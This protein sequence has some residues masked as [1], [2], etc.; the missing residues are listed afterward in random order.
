MIFPHRSPKIYLPRFVESGPKKAYSTRR[1]LQYIWPYL[2]P[3]DRY[4]RLLTFSSAIILIATKSL[5]AYAPFILKE[6]VNSLAAAN[7]LLFYS[8]G[9]FMTYALSRIFVIGLQELRVVL[10]S[11]VIVQAMGDSSRK[12]FSHLHSLDYTFHQQSTRVTMFSVNRSMKAIENYFRLT[13]MYV[14]PTI[15]EFGLATGVL[16]YSCGYPYVITLAGTVSLYSLFTIRYSNVRKVYIREQM[17][18]AKSLDFVINESLVNFEIVKYFSNEKK[19]MERYDYFLKQR[20]A[21]TLKITKSLS[22]LNFGQQVIINTGLGINLL[23]AVN[24][25][26][27]GTMTLGDIFLIQTLFLSLHA[28]LNF[29]G[30]IY[31]ELDEAQ[32]EINSLF[33]IL[34]TKSKVV[35]APNALPYEYKGGRIQMEDVKYTSGKNIFNGISLDIEPGSTNAIIGESGS[36]KTTLF[37]L[38]YR[39]F[40]PDEGSVLIDGQNLKGLTLESLRKS[41]AIV[42]QNPML[43]N[44]TIYYNVTYGSNDATKEQVIEACKLANIHN[45][46]MEFKEGYDSLVGELGSKLSGGEK[47]RLVLARC[48]LRDAKIYLLDEFTSAMDSNNEQEI[49][50]A[51]KKIFKGKT[52]LYNSHRLSSITFVDKIFVISEGKI[53]ETGTHQELLDTPG[54]K[55]SELWTKFISN[56]G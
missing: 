41:I 3:K 17:I 36:G 49:S 20:L 9:M 5:N 48:L 29:L 26:I 32:V 52:V 6:A 47:Q 28:P 53:C 21:G 38:L 8:G 33:E 46:I 39:L 7:P 4:I 42:P 23:L 12:M 13:S 11:K 27:N 1:T 18:K 31:R 56:K 15:L 44:D 2:F 50:E 40:D 30:T 19:E 14:I 16:F 22:N 45:R 25:V 35:E 43:F 55:Y 51:I 34:E 24:Q 10:F 37:R 54:S